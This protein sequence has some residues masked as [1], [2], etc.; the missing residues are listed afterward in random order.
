[1]KKMMLLGI[2]LGSTLHAKDKVTIKNNTN[3]PI[4]YQLNDTRDG[5]HAA[6][7]TIA[8]QT[9]NVAGK[10]DLELDR[11]DVK[12][13]ELSEPKS[14]WGTTVDLKNRHRYYHVKYIKGQ[15]RV[16]AADA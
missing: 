3:K 13:I 5:I 7:G 2:L 11:A 16:I 12:S 9:H 15:Y 14:G 1:M 8:A 10:L 4:S 6:S